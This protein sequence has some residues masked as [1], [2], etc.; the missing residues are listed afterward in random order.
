[1][2]DLWLIGV[3]VLL[4]CVLGLLSFMFQKGRQSKK[5]LETA[6]RERTRQLEIQTEAAEQASRTKSEFLARMSHEIRTPMNAVI[7]MSEL[8]QRDYGSP[9]GLEYLSGIKNAGVSL[10]SIINDILD[11]SK[12][13]SGRLEL[14]TSTYETAHLLNDIL[15]IIRVRMVE[16]PLE[17]IMEADPGLPRALSGDAGRV[18]QIMLNLLSNAVKYTQKGFIRLSVTGERTEA[19][20][21]RLTFVIEDSGIGIKPEDMPKLFG[22]FIRIDEKR[23]SAIEGTGLGLSIARNLCRIMGGD[24]TATSQYG[25]GTAFTATMLQ[26]VDDEKPMGDITATKARRVETQRIS[27]TAPDAEVLV[28]DDFASNLMVAEGLLASYKARVQTC[29][30]GREAVK[31]VKARPFDLVLMDHMMP[32][33][34][35]M[36]ATAA[37]RALGG[38]FAELPIV[39][40]TANAVSGMKEMFLANGFNDFLAKPITTN[41]LDALLQKW[42]PAAKQH[43]VSA[44]DGGVTPE[45]AVAATSPEIA[46][47]DIAAGIARVGGSPSRYRD[48]LRMF[49]RDAEAGFALLA[50]NQDAAGLQAFTTFVHA[51]KSGLA[52]IG[53]NALSRTAAELEQAGRAGDMA[54]IQGNL[55]AF[56]EALT[57]LMARIGEAT[58]PPQSSEA[59][60]KNVSAAQL[61]QIVTELKTAL[62]AKDTDRI[63]IAMEKLQALP[64]AP[65]MRS[66]EGDIT[67]LLLFGDFKKAAAV[68]EALLEQIR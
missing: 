62:D 22:D 42:I 60:L 68:V 38:R 30:N 54:A 51:L 49:C 4:L 48:L 57:A 3:A 36:E 2:S 33:M 7:G 46:D 8:A 20:T 25:K 32:E 37:I 19:Q 45:D 10:L 28:V 43:N 27:F 59:E 55:P 21:I 23:N 56:R 13:E 18:K 17:L 31:L 65:E 12:I 35:G 58:A 16:K 15:D 63:D 61:R 9:K 11:F 34:D 40:L 29:L 50:A 67:Q 47:L 39:A 26:A 64:L 1:S 24:I 41:E 44:T 14:T 66:T 52:N 5:Q 6:V 53:A